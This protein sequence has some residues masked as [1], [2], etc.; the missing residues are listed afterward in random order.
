MATNPR[1]LKELNLA[2]GSGFQAT[3]LVF[4]MGNWSDSVNNEIKKALQDKYKDAFKLIELDAT[5]TNWVKWFFWGLSEK[6]ARII[7]PFIMRNVFINALANTRRSIQLLREVKEMASPPDLIL[8]HNMGALYPAYCLGK[9]YDVPFIFDVED[10]HPGELASAD[11]DNERRRRKYL[12]SKLLPHAKA[13]IS[14]SPLIEQYT[15]DLIGGHHNHS[16]IL[17]SFPESEFNF[18]TTHQHKGVEAL[19]LIW[20]GQKIGPGRG[21]EELFQALVDISRVDSKPIQLTLIG[22]WDAK[23]KTNKYL[24]FQETVLETSISVEILPPLPHVELHSRL[25][26][27][28]IGLALEQGKDLNNKLALSNKI[29]TYTQAGLYVLATNTKAQSQ[30]IKECPDRGMLCGQSASEIRLALEKLLSN[31]KAIFKGKETRFKNGKKLS[32]ELES[33]KLIG[34][35]NDAFKK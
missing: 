17:N 8:A 20:F 6:W 35:W 31:K 22:Y 16:V 23:F 32:W 3:A 29:I 19:K 4:S 14:A 1:L 18:P 28:D 34:L 5:R 33:T 15:L 24:S 21:L 10:Y 9:K 12:L 2:L 25:C 30:F 13:I 7:Y 26:Y 27:N 11:K